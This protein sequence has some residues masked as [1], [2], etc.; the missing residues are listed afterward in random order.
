[1]ANPSKLIRH[2][3]ELD[4]YKLAMD[5]AGSVFVLTKQFPREEIF[6]LTDQIR[7]S[8]RA[9]SALIAEGWRR[10]KYEA[11]FVDKLSQAEGEAAETQAWLEHAVRC[12]YVPPGDARDIHRQCNQ[13]IGKLVKMGNE[14]SRWTLRRSANPVS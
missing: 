5:M 6:S 9:V 4:V 8:S 7:R 10:R 11:A 13:I 1:M 14:P 3:W 12:A 2:H